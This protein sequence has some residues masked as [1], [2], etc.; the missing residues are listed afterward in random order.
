M[1]IIF[2]PSVPFLEFLNNFSSFLFV[3]ALHLLNEELFPHPLVL[4]L[5]GLNLRIT[6]SDFV[7]IFAA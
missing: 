1:L 3:G 6:F 2:L 5:K 7:F 4:S